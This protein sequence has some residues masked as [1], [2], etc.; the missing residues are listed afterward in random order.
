MF[1]CSAG[2][3][4]SGHTARVYNELIAGFAN[5]PNLL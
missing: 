2:F 1:G 3:A 4:G 5:G